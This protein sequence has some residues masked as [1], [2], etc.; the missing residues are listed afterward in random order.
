[1]EPGAYQNFVSHIGILPPRIPVEEAPGDNEM[2]E[3]APAPLN[4]NANWTVYSSNILR[5]DL[6]GRRQGPLIA[7]DWTRDSQEKAKEKEKEPTPWMSSTEPQP[8][9]WDMPEDET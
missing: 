4:L 8:F 6:S 5:G 7:T 3:E 1:M 9:M 2:S